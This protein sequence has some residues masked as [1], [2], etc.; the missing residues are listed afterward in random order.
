MPIIKKFICIVKVDEKTFLRYHVNNLLSF[1]NFLD[2]KYDW[3]WFNVFS[4]EPTAFGQQIAN[5]T[6][7]SRP[8]NKYVHYG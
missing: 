2:R 5:F 7:N 8:T 3:K 4:H 6:K 1:T